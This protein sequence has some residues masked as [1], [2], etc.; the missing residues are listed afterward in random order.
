MENRA[1]AL[2]AG[3]FTLLLVAGV[4]LAAM[5]FSG[6]T[7]EKAYYQL[8]SKFPVTG[9]NE[10]AVV[11]FRGVDIGKVTKIQFDPANVRTILVDV[12]IR[13]SVKLTRSAFAELRYQGVTGLS[14]V[15]LDDP[16]TS[17][18]QLPQMTQAG[19]SRIPIHESLF[20]NLAEAGQAALA[21]ARG[22]MQRM[23]KVLSDENQAQVSRTLQNIE[24]ATQQIVTLTQGLQPAA[25]NSEALVADARKTFQTADK[26][27]TE[28]SDTNRQLATRLEAVDRV[29]GSAEKAGN[30]IVSLANNVSSETLP[31]VNALADELAR[32]SRSLDRLATSLREQPQSLVFGRKA[33]SLGPGEGEPAPRDKAK[34]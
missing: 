13:S 20:S 23:S 31:R 26:L 32:T 21:D 1:H 34:P 24:A 7:Y 30:A 19:S 6:E 22:L 5:W 25:R 4:I 8:E 28:I 17:S 12:A 29:A 10:E 2:A 27:L 16:G 3:L 15:M 14:Y 18:E 11:R 9:L 33:T